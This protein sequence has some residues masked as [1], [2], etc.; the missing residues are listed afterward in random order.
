MDMILEM[1]VKQ[2]SVSVREVVDA[3]GFSR[4]SVTSNLRKLQQAGTIEA[5]ENRNNPRQRYRLTE[6]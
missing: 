5:T 2:D 1:L 6:K 3:T 4:S